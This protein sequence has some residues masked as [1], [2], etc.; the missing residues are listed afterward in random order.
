MAFQRQDLHANGSGARNR[1]IGGNFWANPLG[2]GYS[3]TCVD[4][5]YNGFCDVAYNLSQ[6]DKENYDYL[7]FSDKYD[8]TPPVITIESPESKIYTDIAIDLK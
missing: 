8:Q 4:S 7:A 2:T 6:N 1:D 3:E 5:D